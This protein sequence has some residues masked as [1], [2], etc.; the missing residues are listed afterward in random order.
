ML[1]MQSVRFDKIAGK[2][3]IDHRLP[4]AILEQPLI[5]PARRDRGCIKHITCGLAH[6]QYDGPGRGL[7]DSPICIR[8]MT[9][10]RR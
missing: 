4:R 8:V 9:G 6:G 10:K 3:R 2:R 1:K 7:K 5:P